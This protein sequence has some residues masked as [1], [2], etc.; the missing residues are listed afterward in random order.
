[1]GYQALLFC[2]EEKTA[3]TVT[4]V[5]SE[6]EFTVEASAE[7]FAA[8]KKL[9][10]Q[11][12]D[13]VV[14]DCDN[15]QN[16]TL[17]F[18]SARNSTSNQASLAVAVVEGQAGVAKAFRIGANLV[19]TKP[20]NVEQAK[21]TLRVARGLLRKG[22]PAKPA[23]P[24]AIPAASS[25]PVKTA[26]PAAAKSASPA[27]P[28]ARPTVAA[29][30]KPA[31]AASWP[32][33]AA[34]ASLS[35][36][37]QSPEGIHKEENAA[38][39]AAASTV[40]KAPAAP[41]AK[42]A[43]SPT[44]SSVAAQKPAPAAKAGATAFGSGAASAPAPA[45]EVPEVPVAESAAVAKN[46]STDQL[47]KPAEAQSAGTGS[48]ASPAPAPSFSLSTDVTAEASVD[49]KKIFLGIAAVVLVVA[50]IVT[51][52]Q[53]LG[54]KPQ[55]ASNTTPAAT[56]PAATAPAPASAQPAPA[57]TTPSASASQPA[58]QPVTAAAKPS[59]ATDDTESA[60]EDTRSTAPSSAK[61]ASSASTDSSKPAAA[62]KPE[63]A[64]LVVKGGAQPK[65]AKATAPDAP[66]APSMIGIATPGAGGSLPNIVDNTGIA[67]KPILQSLNV[68]QGVSQGLLMKK[69][70]PIYPR[71]ALTMHVEGTV[72]LMATIAKSGDITAIKL[73]SG[74]P[75]LTSAATDAV[76]Q[77]KYKP[78]LLN[79]EPVEIQ[80]QV[81][82]VF[83]L[84]R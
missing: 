58:N 84:P 57:T 46:A 69:V 42:T 45:R 35:A 7:P 43:A 38:A 17:L 78:Y 27:V 22:E 39:S 56:T 41:G 23:V 77:W 19:L 29:P 20:I 10:G 44:I 47:D 49:R 9:M 61:P 14:V 13:A 21:G 12:F 51:A 74:P 59:A 5:L 54:K 18:K 34:A 6:L 67:P 71:T 3:R 73:L 40:K 15:E 36:R 28:V 68:S 64:P 4:Q 83:R 1:M 16:A 31:A 2:P 55:A 33:Q 24:G 60:R 75:Q 50:G 26:P 65:A 76:K 53:L 48:F 62:A 81:T 72:Q 32:T 8:V 25:T 79:G 30:A 11:H 37:A 80:T 66:A 82:V 52:W 63:P 70:Q